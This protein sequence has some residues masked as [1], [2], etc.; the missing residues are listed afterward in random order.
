VL[1]EAQ[2]I[3]EVLQTLQQET[4]E[5]I[6]VDG[7][8]RDDTIALAQTFTQQSPASNVKII[9]ASPGRAHQMNTG[10]AIAT[11]EIL[12]FLHADTRLPPGFPALVIQTLESGAIA[13]AFTL[14]IAGE[15]PGLR[16][17]ER[18]VQWRSRHLQLPYGDQAIFLKASQF[19]AIGVFADL[20]IMEDFDLVR[21]LQKL[22]K[23]A[24][25]PAPVLT[26][27]RRWQKLGIFQTTV[28]NQGAI[29]AYFLG[30]SPARIARW[31]RGK[32]V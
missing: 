20:P 5:I 17:I 7:G 8:S 6:V 16:W 19:R 10:A 13:G 23:I 25:V 30:V 24:I 31:Y 2:W 26:S 1:N 29:V 32:S 28:M 9:S 18:G 21:R 27:D 3:Q 11:G 4:L 14:Q 22:G 15:M 12:L